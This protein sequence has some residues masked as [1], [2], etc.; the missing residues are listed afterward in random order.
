MGGIKIDVD[1]S[2]PIF[3]QIVSEIERL[4]LVGEIKTADFI[5]SVREFSMKHGINPNTVA[6]AY[7]LLQFNGLVEFVRG[8]G[9]RV[10]KQDLK[11]IKKK[12]A[13]LLQ[14]KAERFVKEAEA[15]GFKEADILMA[16]KRVKQGGG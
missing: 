14:E 15:L 9:L 1:S 13:N 7:N 10:K 12:R 5:P 4:I 8:T 16:I 11:D 3:Q 2:V 6:K